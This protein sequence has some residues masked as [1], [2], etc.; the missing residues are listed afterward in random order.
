MKKLRMNK[1]N[2]QIFTDITRQLDQDELKAFLCKKFP[3][4][5]KPNRK[6]SPSFQNKIQEY[7][8]EKSEFEEDLDFEEVSEENLAKNKEE[9]DLYHLSSSEE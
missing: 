3:K 7:E 4:T 2:T 1:I 8:D 6:K 9:N 5:I